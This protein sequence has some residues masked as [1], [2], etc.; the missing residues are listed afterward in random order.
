MGGNEKYNLVLDR[1]EKLRNM[2]G[3]SDFF[4]MILNPGPSLTYLTGLHFHLMERPVVVLFRPFQPLI[5][6]LPALESAKLSALPYPVEAF[7]YDEN[8]ATWGTIF[9]EALKKA[10]ISDGI[11]GVEP[12]RLRVLELEFLRKAAPDVKFESAAE[13]LTALRVRKDASEIESMRKAVQVA[14]EAI[15]RTLAHIKIGVQEREMAAELVLQLLRTGSEPELPFFPIVGFGPNSANPHAHPSD[16]E[17]SPGDLVLFD[18]GATV[19]GYVSDITRVFVVGDPDPELAKIGKIV[20]EANAAARAAAGPG[21]PAGEVD[22]AARQ[23]IDAAG[24]GPYFYHRTGHGIGLEGHEEPYIRGDNQE[25]LETGN[26]FTIEP[27]I[28]LADRGGVRIE[29]NVV[30]T[31]EGSMSLTDLPRTLEPLNI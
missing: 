7:T 1:Q 11:I 28:Y 6:I 15:R 30:I 24:Y 8:P 13:V 3:E 26:T 25:R 29:D 27:G 18:W 2:L 10:Q 14:Q 19:D 5:I 21:V 4:G 22:L 23:I 9:S 17:L 20:R 31:S 12:R 16:R